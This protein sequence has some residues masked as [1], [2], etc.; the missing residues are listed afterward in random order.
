[1]D[2]NKKETPSVFSELAKD[3]PLF[4]LNP[5]EDELET[6]RRVVLRGEEP[7]K[8]NLGHYRGSEEDRLETADTPAG[9]V[10]VA[11][12]GN[13]MDFELVVRGLM[14]AKEGP[15]KKV[16]ESQGAAMLYV[17]N[18]RRI[19]EYLS[20]FP[21]NEKDEEFRRFTS[22]KANYLDILVVL[23]RGP[24]S[25]VPAGTVR[26]TETA[27]LDY[28]D[29]IRRVH[30]LTHVVCRRLYPDN[31]DPLR[32]EL[33]ADAV[34]LIAAFGHF[35]PELEK[36]FLGIRG[37]QYTGGR[38]GNYTE[39][40]ERMVP[41]IC[42]GINRIRELAGRQSRQDPFDLIPV[43]MKQPLWEPEP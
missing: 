5:D 37:T 1:M 26:Y 41:R 10:R 11:T 24:Y 34:G 39:E 3:Y 22:D 16:P 17:F 9:P 6:Y 35:D 33:I 32:D 8:K 21:E 31:I 23:S 42:T 43:L 15:G 36:L 38:L 28:S 30:E 25:H 13:R 27:W 14:A 12:L 18:W 29:T 7:E 40:P 2:R 4:Y 19:H 20:A